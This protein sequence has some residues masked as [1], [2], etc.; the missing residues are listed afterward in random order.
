MSLLRVEKL[1][2]GYAG[3]QALWDVS[4]KVDKGECVALVG[5]NSAG[6]TTLLKTIAGLVKPWKGEIY[7]EENPISKL[8]TFEVVKSGI[9]YISEEKTL[10][11]Y[12]TV[13][14]NLIL[15][16]YSIED[17]AKIISSLDSTIFKNFPKL[18]ERQGQLAGKL[19]GGEQ[20]MCSIARALM[21]QPHI[22]LIDELS[23]GLA[24][25]VVDTLVEILKELNKQG[26]TILLVE[27]NT[28]VALELSSRTYVLE[29]GRIV[30]EGMSSE[31]SNN[32]Y[33]KEAYLGIK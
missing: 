28:E 5:A 22:L 30:M 17:R 12:L 7:F 16:A 20:Q 23:L 9:V 15:G 18:K 21:A 26:L 6:K 27:Q 10:F 32:P 14:D 13:R 11:P 24:P 8:E 3:I 19:S 31:L 29:N 1:S 2:T 4:L 33:V 25:V